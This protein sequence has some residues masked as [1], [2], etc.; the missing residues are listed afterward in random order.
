MSPNRFPVLLRMANPTHGNMGIAYIGVTRFIKEMKKGKRMGRRRSR[1]RRRRS[2]GGVA[3]G[4]RREAEKR[5]GG[6]SGRS[7]REG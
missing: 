3:A 5:R 6:H 1:R 4:G 2:R 7:W